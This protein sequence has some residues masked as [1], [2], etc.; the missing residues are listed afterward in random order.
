MNAVKLLSVK[1]QNNR[2]IC[3]EGGDC[4]IHAKQSKQSDTTSLYSSFHDSL[5]AK[6]THTEQ[7]NN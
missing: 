1:Y 6:L 7:A 3:Q 5:E 2:E 4:N